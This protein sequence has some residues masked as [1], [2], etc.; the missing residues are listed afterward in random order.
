MPSSPRHALELDR[1]NGNDDWDQSMNLELGQLSDYKMFRVLEDHE[2]MPE[3]YKRIPYHMVFDMKFDLRKKLRLVAA[4]NH[5]DNPKE[6]IYSGVVSLE[7]LRMAF[8]MAAMNDLKVMAADVGNAFL[9]GRTK[10]KV[11]IV[12]GPE[13]G[14]D[15]GK[16]MII[17]KGL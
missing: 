4:G 12:A 9:C 11:H 1:L 10:E 17:E 5:T 16:H 7:S 6:D 2:K 8:L 15:A 14:K 13:F 3:G